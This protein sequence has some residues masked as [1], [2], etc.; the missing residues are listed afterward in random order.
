[1]HAQHRFK[2]ERAEPRRGAARL[3]AVQQPQFRQLQGL[4]WQEPLLQ[5]QV[6]AAFVVSLVMVILLC[7][8]GWFPIGESAYSFRTMVR[9]QA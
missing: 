9:S 4:H 7:L 6:Q 1:L 8:P 2:P 3:G 5:E